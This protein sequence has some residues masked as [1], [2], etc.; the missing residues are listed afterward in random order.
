MEPM[1]TTARRAQDWVRGRVSPSTWRRAQQA[2]QAVVG[3]RRGPSPLTEQIGVGRCGD[4]TI[5]PIA[6]EDAAAWSAA[7]RANAARMQPWWSFGESDIDLMTDR[8]AFENHLHA[9]DV[10][11]TRGEG[12][13]LAL[14]GPEGLFGEMQVWH[15]SPGGLTAEIGLWMATPPRLALQAGGCLGY[16]FDR[17]FGEVGLQRIDAPVAAANPLP[18]PF[19]SLGGFEVDAR[20]PRWRELGGELADYDLFGLTDERWAAARQAGEDRTGPWRRIG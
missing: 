18:R 8:M 17:L 1:Q 19:L 2:K 13:C 3:L 6:A 15:L 14:V 10:R 12:V 7:M 5:R 16:A 9:W 11:R 4:V 20:I